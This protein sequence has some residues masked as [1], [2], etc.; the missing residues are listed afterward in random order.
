MKIAMFTNN[1]K[2]FVGGVP[3]SIE[4]LA[5][6][7]R[8]FGH[9]VYIFAPSY[10][11]QV[12][13]EYIIRY[14]SLKHKIQ[15]HIVIPNMMDKDIEKTFKSMNFDLIHVHHPMLIG[16]TALYLGKKYHLPVVYTYHTRYEHYLHYLKIYDNLQK[17]YESEKVGFLRQ[18]EGKLISFTNEFFV[19]YHNR[20]FT[21]RCDFVFAPTPYMKQHLI[22]RGTKSPI[23]I[24]PTG[25]AD[26][27][28]TCDSSIVDEIRKKYA[29]KNHH[30]FCTVS[31][32]EKEKNF[33][34]L[35][36]SIKKYKEIA[37]TPFYCLIIGDG[38]ER[39]NLTKQTKELGLQDNVKFLGCI[40]HE[41]LKNYYHACDLFLFAS[42]SETQGIVL[43]EAMAAS[44]P[45]IAVNASGVC[46]VVKQ[47][48][49]GFMTEENT[50][51]F[52]SRIHEV[53]NNVFEL[54]Q[55][56]KGA[57][58]EST[59]YTNEIIAGKAEFIYKTLLCEK[60]E[61]YIHA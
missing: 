56:Q 33:D 59:N 55:L 46:D 43:L 35:L 53:M 37:A 50:E 40:P 61:L 60:E 15:H 32:L 17:K 14:R 18:M 21:N 1:Y 28:F 24:I 9:T 13:D 41:E 27:D 31:R 22:E 38:S 29:T 5:N 45:V 2:P 30:L 51:E 47:S 26:D 8:K 49:N 19:P 16:Y 7:L 44:L 25:L 34:F 12:D 36:Q 42:K 6:G 52:A 48:E 54:K 10:E 4:R 58:Y 20:L 39:N 57:Y 11:N 3:I 23:E